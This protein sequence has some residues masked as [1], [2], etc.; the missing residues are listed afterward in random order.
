MR[1]HVHIKAFFGIPEDAV[2]TQLWIAMSV[3]A[4]VEIL[5]RRLSREH[6]SL[7]QISPSW[8]V[9]IVETSPVNSLFLQENEECQAID[10]ANSCH[11]SAYGWTAAIPTPGSTMLWYNQG[12]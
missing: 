4:L 7:W 2:K 10:P 12:K 5:R 11:S 1:R 3:N 9:M 8:H 6:L